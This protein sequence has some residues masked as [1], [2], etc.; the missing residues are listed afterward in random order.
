VDDDFWSEGVLDDAN[1]VATI[2][3][4][5][6]DERDAIQKRPKIWYSGFSSQ[7]D[8]ACFEG[9][10]TYKPDAI[11]RIKEYAPQ[12]EKLCAIA[13]G[14]EATCRV[15]KYPF[16]VKI[17]HSDRYNH[18]RTMNFDFRMEDDDTLDDETEEA[19]KGLLR[20]FAKWIYKSLEA[21]YNATQTDEYIDDAIV[22]NEYEFLIDGLRHTL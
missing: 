14:L 12:D 11:E 1:R 7:G 20:D 15:V 19:I 5:E 2:L 3:G 21:A 17:T 4:I 8:G 16:L 18:E 10:F 13:D 9:V 22:A 6:I